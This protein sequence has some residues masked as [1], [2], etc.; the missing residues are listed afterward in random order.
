VDCKHGQMVL[1]WLKCLNYY[2]AAT[3]HEFTPEV[4]V[5][6]KKYKHSFRL[7]KVNST[8]LQMADEL[9]EQ[10]LIDLNEFEELRKVDHDFRLFSKINI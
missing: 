6:I 1:T 9:L 8:R 2:N 10:N 3:L 7:R 5:D 4:Y